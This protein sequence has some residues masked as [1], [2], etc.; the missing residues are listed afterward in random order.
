MYP[1]FAAALR[2]GAAV[3]QL[4]PPH[5]HRADPRLSQALRTMARPH[6]TIGPGPPTAYPSSWPETRRLLLVAKA[7]TMVVCL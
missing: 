7:G 5:L 1:G 4:D 6:D 2:A 3:A